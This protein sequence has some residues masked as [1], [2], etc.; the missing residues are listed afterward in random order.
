MHPARQASSQV[1]PGIP[2]NAT[3]ADPVAGP[4][5]PPCR[6]GFLCAC[7]RCAAEEQLLE[8]RPQLDAA[9]KEA[10]AFVT[11]EAQPLLF[12]ISDGTRDY[13][14]D[15]GLQEQVRGRGSGGAA[16]TQSD[17]GPS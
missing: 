17:W 15:E 3:A 6:Y 5:L 13:A 16:L 4:P 10:L 1:Q 8:G 9:V 12:A 11:E 2:R 7:E 14:A